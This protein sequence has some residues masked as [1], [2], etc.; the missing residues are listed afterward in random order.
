MKSLLRKIAKRLLVTVELVMLTEEVMLT[1]L[2][3]VVDRYHCY[4]LN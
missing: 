4:L 1:N 3:R 2:W